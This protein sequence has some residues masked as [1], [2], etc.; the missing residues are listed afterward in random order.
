MNAEIYK[1]AK[2][3]WRWRLRARNG[4]ILADSGQGYVRKID[5]R[6]GL[7]LVLFENDWIGVDYPDGRREG[8]F[9]RELA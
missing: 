1:D 6:L 5:A 8:A 7:D 4:R 9:W 2:G 3:K